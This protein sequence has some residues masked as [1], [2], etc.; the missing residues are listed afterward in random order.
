MHAQDDGGTPSGTIISGH[1]GAA[2]VS[3][4]LIFQQGKNTAR[5]ISLPLHKTNVIHIYF[6]LKLRTVGLGRRPLCTVDVVERELGRVI[7]IIGS[8]PVLGHLSYFFRKSA[9][10]ETSFYINVYKKQL[11]YLIR[12]VHEV[13]ENLLGH[14]FIG[15]SIP[16]E[17]RSDSRES[18]QWAE[19]DL[20]LNRERSQ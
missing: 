12:G 16:K 19:T 6:L 4:H 2:V 8:T 11:G 1:K 9:T 7:L 10:I 20:L 15:S 14:L 18:S 17:E 13:F 3:A 5:A